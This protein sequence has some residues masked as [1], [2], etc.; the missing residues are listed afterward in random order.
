MSARY[1]SGRNALLICRTK[2]L[3]LFTN[4]IVSNQLISSSYCLFLTDCILY[5]CLPYYTLKYFLYIFFI[6]YSL[7]LFY[8][9]FFIFRFLCF[10]FWRDFGQSRAWGFILSCCKAAHWILEPWFVIHES[11]LRR[12]H[13]VLS[14]CVLAA[15]WS[16]SERLSWEHNAWIIPVAFET[17]SWLTPPPE[18]KVGRILKIK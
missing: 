13:C 4:T 14:G 1:E 5:Y 6:D 15:S 3:L 12:S 7:Y 17:H 10:L 11:I 16:H 18:V 2:A 8:V 9:I